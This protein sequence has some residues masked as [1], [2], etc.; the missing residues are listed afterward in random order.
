[1]EDELQKEM[2]EEFSWLIDAIKI[3][4]PPVIILLTLAVVLL[5][6]ENRRLSNLIESMHDE[7]E[8]MF[9]EWKTETDTRTERL[10]TAL[11]NNTT[12]INTNA[13]N[14]ESVKGSLNSILM[15]IAGVLK[16]KTDGE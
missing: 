4:G 16:G 15:V 2:I 11:S 7:K 13:S 9:R 5:L 6:R 12:A 1:M 8:K 10:L 14:T 3:G